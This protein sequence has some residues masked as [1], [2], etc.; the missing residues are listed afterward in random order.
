MKDLRKKK[1]YVVM[2]VLCVLVGKL[3]TQSTKLYVSII[4]HLSRNCTSVLSARK[5]YDLFG[6]VSSFSPVC[7]HGSNSGIRS[8]MGTVPCLFIYA[9]KR[10]WNMFLIRWKLLRSYH[11]PVSLFKRQMKQL[12]FHARVQY[13]KSS[14]TA[15]CLSDPNC[16]VVQAEMW[17]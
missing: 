10:Q 14:L 4:C 3:W 13:W 12:D 1:L 6:V 15:V 7:I 16:N 5:R 17:H 2:D 8:I 11:V 9:L